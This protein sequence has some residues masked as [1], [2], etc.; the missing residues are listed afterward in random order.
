MA[1]ELRMFGPEYLPKHERCKACGDVFKSGD[2]STLISLG[3]GEDPEAQEKARE[4]KPY[5]AVAIKI[6]W[7]CAT[8][9]DPEPKEETNGKS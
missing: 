3:P 1:E 7:K 9:K 6:H 8:G 4:G 5:N 2:Y